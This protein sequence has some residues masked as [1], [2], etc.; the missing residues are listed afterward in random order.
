MSNVT[1][2]QMR[3]GRTLFYTECLILNFGDLIHATD[4]VFHKFSEKDLLVVQTQQFVTHY[5]PWYPVCTRHIYRGEI[6]FG[7]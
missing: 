1:D 5:A 7:L 4:H 2:V 3:D 6:F